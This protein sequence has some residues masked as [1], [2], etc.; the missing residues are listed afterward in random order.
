MPHGTGH[1]SK[2]S[3]L[4][5]DFSAI[6]EIVQRLKSLNPIKIIN[7]ASSTSNNFEGRKNAQIVQIPMIS[8]M[9][10]KSS[11]SPCLQ[12]HT[13]LKRFK[14]PICLLLN[15]FLFLLLRYLITFSV[16]RRRSAS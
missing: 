9:R 8:R 16:L 4:S 13:F 10:P 15:I 2:K 5:E 6:M 7:P 12:Q 14:N 11:A 3:S 1:I